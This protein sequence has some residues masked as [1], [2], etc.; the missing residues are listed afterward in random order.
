MA[1]CKQG[2]GL[3]KL[4]GKPLDLVEPETLRLKVKEPIL[5]LGTKVF[6]QVDIRVRVK[7]GGHVAQIYAVRQ[8]LAKAVVAYYQKCKP[9]LLVI[10]SAVVFRKELLSEQSTF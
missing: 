1:H 8:A 7:G 3:I 10:F 5:L 9:T 4:N 6:N 2:R